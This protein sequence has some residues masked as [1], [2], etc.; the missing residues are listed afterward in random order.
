MS[1]SQTRSKEK[2]NVINAPLFPMIPLTRVV[3]DN[4]HMFLRISDTLIDLLL[5]E[6]RRLDCIDKAT[7][8]KTLDSLTY[9]KLYENTLK[10]IGVG[11][12]SFWIG[13]E[14]RKLKYRTLTG[15]EKLILFDKLNIAETFPQVPNVEKVQLLW[16]DLLRINRMLATR[17]EEITPDVV[18]E[19]E[20]KAKN[21]L[22]Q[23][24]Q[25]YPTKFVTPYMYCMAQ[26]VAEF[27]NIHGAI[28]PFTQQGLEKFNDTM[29]KDYFRSSSHRGVECLKQILQKQNRMEH[30]EHIGARRTQPSKCCSQCGGKGHNIRTCPQSSS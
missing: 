29:T 30:L 28:L 27:F 18:S 19:F 2:Y 24:V 26:H 17:P 22:K 13:K 3:V 6:L 15:P 14:S 7:K 12:F 1:L 23:F 16:T 8:L 20:K 11:G 5:L 10:L 9:L 21:F 25:I 4:L